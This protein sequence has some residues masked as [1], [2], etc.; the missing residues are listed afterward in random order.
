M[1]CDLWN[2]A[3][4]LY[5][6]R[7]VESACLELQEA[8]ADVCLLLTAAWLEAR[9]VRRSAERL[10]QLR[11]LAGPWQAQAIA[12]LRTLRQ[13]WKGIEAFGQL[14][15]R[16]KALELDAERELL[17]HLAEQ[18]AAWLEDTARQPDDWLAE[19]AGEAG[20]MRPAALHRLRGGA[21]A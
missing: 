7:H 19:L 18:A 2:F 13:G 4:D 10:E 17:R 11:E 15:E 12:P 21:P 5:R 9:R 8:G 3:V 20:R 14:R 6:Q 16:L 1:P